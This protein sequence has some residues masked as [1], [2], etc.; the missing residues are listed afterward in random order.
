MGQISFRIDD[1]LKAA[2]EKTFK[3]MGMTM[4]TAI[5]VFVTQAVK[6]QRF[7]FAI[8]AGGGAAEREA[9]PL[10]EKEPSRAQ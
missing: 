10:S 3:D 6:L 7:P 9:T 4:S 5:T 2:A 1:D 8:E